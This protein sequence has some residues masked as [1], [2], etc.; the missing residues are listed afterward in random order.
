MSR[1]MYSATPHVALHCLQMIWNYIL[2]LVYISQWSKVLE[3]LLPI[4][5]KSGFYINHCECFKKWLMWYKVNKISMKNCI[6]VIFFYYLNNK[7][8]LLIWY[9][10]KVKKKKEYFEIDY[11]LEKWK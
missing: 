8:K 1:S 2:R 7:K 9:K 10:K 6:I 5:A 11:F 4:I 3:V